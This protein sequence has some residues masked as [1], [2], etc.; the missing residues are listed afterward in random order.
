MSVKSQVAVCGLIVVVVGIS[1]GAQAGE[2]V[3]AAGDSSRSSAQDQRTHALAGSD[4]GASPTRK[5]FRKGYKYRSKDKKRRY[6]LHL[7]PPIGEGEWRLYAD[8]LMGS[9]AQT[10]L[11]E[12]LH[13]RYLEEDWTF[14]EEHAEPLYRR[15]EDIRAAGD[16]YEE[17]AT[18][19]RFVELLDVQVRVSAQLIPIEERMFAE[20]ALHLTEDQLLRL[21]WVRKQRRRIRSLP[22]GPTFPAGKIDLALA[23]RDVEKAGID[24]RPHD[25]EAFDALLW[26]YDLA[27]TPLC[28]QRFRRGMSILKDGVPLRAQA[29]IVAM[30]ASGDE[31]VLQRA[32]AINEQYMQYNRAYVLAAKRIHDLN[33]RY[34][35]LFAD[36]LPD[37][38]A[39]ALG[40]WF[41]ERA[42]PAIFPD[43]YDFEDVLQKAAEI[44]TLSP[45]E[46]KGVRAVGI[47]YEQQHRAICDRMIDEYLAWH[48][49]IKTLSGYEFEPYEAYKTK[50]RELQGKRKE[51]A[52]VAQS[53]MEGLLTAEEMGRL[54]ESLER[55][56]ASALAFEQR[57]ERMME[58]Y[59]FVIEWPGPYD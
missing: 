41:R 2:E 14:R 52:E 40:T 11:F 31:P 46:R 17:L 57:G 35:D 37:E 26:A 15:S 23:I 25:A 36:Q 59:G 3:G 44:E 10:D 5:D 45:E 39:D 32:E 16:T 18:A 34:L 27:V 49:E 24:C 1:G 55:W 22:V 51:A 33:R 43:P 42:Y 20:L 29:T 30:D 53:L 8:M 4:S 13:L 54:G 19:R 28:E 48:V 58:Q 38:A 7:P 9:D 47:F 50:M 12:K 21:E 56:R 6:S